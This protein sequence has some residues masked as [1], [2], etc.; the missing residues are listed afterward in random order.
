ML[1][2]KYRLVFRGL[3][4]RKA[5]DELDAVAQGLFLSVPFGYYDDGDKRRKYHL[6]GKVRLYPK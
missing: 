3:K 6:S 2:V 4:L 1:T 5:F